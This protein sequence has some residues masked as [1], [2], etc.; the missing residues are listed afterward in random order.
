MVAMSLGDGRLSMLQ[1]DISAH[2]IP[3]GD[4]LV[5]L[6]QADAFMDHMAAFHAT[7]WGW[8]D[9]VG[10]ASIEQRLNFFSD[11]NIA[12]ETQA[13]EPPVPIVVAQQ[14]WS[15][16]PDRLTEAGRP[17]RADARQPDTAR[18]PTA[19]AAADVHHGR[20]EDG[21]PRLQ[22]AD[23]ATIL[24]DWA[25]PGAACGLWDLVWYLGVNRARLP[26]SKEDTIDCYRGRA[27]ARGIATG[28]L[29]GQRAAHQRRRPDVHDGVGESR[30]RRRRTRV[31]G[32]RRYCA[33]R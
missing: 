30:R 31:V 12:R 4:A 6:E 22:R 16:L 24:L 21:Q 9:D 32:R 3:E 29:V 8:T 18:R 26:R 2:L 25:Y 15:M 7:F 5:T 17:A 14:G 28:R 23:A 11:D 20:L 19:L 1:R 13:A 33:I 27:R 10:V